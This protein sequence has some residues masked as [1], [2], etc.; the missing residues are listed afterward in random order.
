MPNGDDVYLVK[1]FYF[2]NMT[3]NY[4]FPSPRVT[5]FVR[6]NRSFPGVGHTSTAT[7]NTTSTHNFFA[8]MAPIDAA[9][10]FLRSSDKPNIVEAAWT[11]KVE[12]SAL[13]KH[14]HEKRVSI[15]KAN[16]T[17]QL[18]TKKQELV[19]VNEIQ[20]LC[21]W[22]LPPTPGTSSGQWQLADLGAACAIC[23][24]GLAST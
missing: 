2:N 7:N 5:N 16:E 17:K 15:A 20:R 8:T 10:A 1:V 11:F 22:C 21:D 14:F 4:C 3:K 18:L 12:R 6:P 19:L 13:R 24:Y 9:I 23:L